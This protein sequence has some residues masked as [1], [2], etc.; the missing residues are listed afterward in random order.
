MLLPICGSKAGHPGHVVARVSVGASGIVQTLQVALASRRRVGRGGLMGVSHAG[1]A[2]TM[3]KP[4]VWVG[5]ITT[6][7]NR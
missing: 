6:I 5:Q 4:T 2:R 7:E 1:A 3:A